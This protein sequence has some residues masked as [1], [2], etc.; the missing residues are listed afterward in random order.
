MTL[1][2]ANMGVPMLFVQMPAMAAALV[3]IIAIEALFIRPRLAISYR[4]ALTG[5]SIANVV[6]T[7]IGIPVAWFVL[8]V[9]EMCFESRIYKF[10]DRLHEFSSPLSMTFEMLATFPWLAPDEA[11][12]Y[13]MV[14]VASALLLLP[15]YF[16]SIW[17]ERP[18]CRRAWRHVDSSAT[19]RAVT[20][21]NQLSYAALFVL[22]CGWL[23][24]SILTHK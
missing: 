8:V 20:H 2:L 15:S 12:L 17:L 22:A 7:I 13:W 3:P 16:A 10:T 4:E 23:G 18:I 19:R 5:T 14:P 21:A 6:S 11:R 9:P 24:Y 1:I